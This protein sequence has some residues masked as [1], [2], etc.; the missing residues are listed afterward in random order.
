MVK[1][2]TDYPPELSQPIFVSFL[3]ALSSAGNLREELIYE[4]RK[5]KFQLLLK[6][7]KIDLSDPDAFLYLAFDLA[8]KH[9]KG[10]EV[11]RTPPRGVG[12]P[13]IKTPMEMIE[14][15]GEIQLLIDKGHSLSRACELLAKRKT[16]KW[17]GR[18]PLTLAN[19]SREAKKEVARLKAS[20][21]A[22]NLDQLEGLRGLFFPTGTQKLPRE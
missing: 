20:G 7:Y 21:E 8:C 13:K 17:Y 6:H 16:S 4:A 12:R 11:T 19:Q 22:R 2:N 10:F 18:N 14:L 5:A 3:A 1:K 9:I 15:Y